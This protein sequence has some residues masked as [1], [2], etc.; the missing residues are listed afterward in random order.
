MLGGKDILNVPL[1]KFISTNHVG[2]DFVVGDIHGCYSTLIKLLEKIEFHKGRDRL[3][4]VGDLVNRG[5]DSIECLGLLKQPWFFSVRGNHEQMLI[6]YL[7]RPDKTKPYDS[8]WLTE[9]FQSHSDRQRFS[10]QW[11]H[12]LD[13]L[14]LVMGVGLESPHKNDQFYVVHGE[15]LDDR[16]TVTP[17]MI[18]KW[19]FERPEKAKQRALWGRALIQAWKS[20]LN[21]A[22][23]HDKEMPPIICGH[24]IVQ[25]PV[26]LSKQIFI[27]LGAYYG[28]NSI[29]KNK[30]TECI[31]P[32]LCIFEPKTNQ[33]WTINSITQEIS[34]SLFEDAVQKSI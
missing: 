18:N 29:Y 13:R 22:R 33:Y 7:R 24:T 26:Q 30:N 8:V 14:P 4:S 27:D 11:L 25:Q 23:A 3:F 28:Y 6:D 19:S 16:R 17:E 20:C 12:S 1:T 9:V 31:T 2:R 15:L 10:A 5:P 32:S 21:V 34:K